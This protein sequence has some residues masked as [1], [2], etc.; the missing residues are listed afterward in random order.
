[1]SSVNC[2]EVPLS[3]RQCVQLCLNLRSEIPEMC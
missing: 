3:L 1:M 2:I